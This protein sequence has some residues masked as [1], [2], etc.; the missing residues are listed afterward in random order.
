[1]SVH[2]S[3]NILHHKQNFCWSEQA[4]R[5]AIFLANSG[6][7][8]EVANTSFDNENIFII[9]FVDKIRYKITTTILFKGG[10]GGHGNEI[11]EFL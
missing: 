8:L 7:S 1:M 5:M 4:I 2:G 6:K 9:V 3:R 11:F 10:G